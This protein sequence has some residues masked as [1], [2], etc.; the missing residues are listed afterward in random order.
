MLPAAGVQ[1]LLGLPSDLLHRTVSLLAQLIAGQP[2][3]PVSFTSLAV[4]HDA[5]WEVY[6]ATSVFGTHAPTLASAA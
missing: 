5:L 6:A 1:L 2:G 4:W 3:C